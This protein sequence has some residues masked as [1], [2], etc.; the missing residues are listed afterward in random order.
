MNR[1]QKHDLAKQMLAA[2]SESE[3]EK[4]ISLMRKIVGNLDSKAGPSLT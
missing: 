3:Q 2:L 1:Q 4:L